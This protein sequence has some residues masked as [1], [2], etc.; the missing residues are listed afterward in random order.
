MAINVSPTPVLHVDDPLFIIAFIGS[1]LYAAVK[2]RGPEPMPLSVPRMDG[3]TSHR[4]KQRKK[5]HLVY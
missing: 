4:E 3:A 5:K 2:V 1:Y